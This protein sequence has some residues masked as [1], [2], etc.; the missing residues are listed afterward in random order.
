MTKRDHQKR[1]AEKTVRDIRERLDASIQPRAAASDKYALPDL[2]ASDVFWIRRPES[3]G[4]IT[5]EG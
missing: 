2:P 1:S 5:S 4:V 3:Y